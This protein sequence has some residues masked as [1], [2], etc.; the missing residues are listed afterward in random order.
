MEITSEQLK[1]LNKL[2]GIKAKLLKTYFGYFNP[3]Y[4][5]NERKVYL[6]QAVRSSTSSINK[7][8][9]FT[10]LLDN[11]KCRHAKDIIIH[12]NERLYEIR[13]DLFPETENE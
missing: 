5:K 10:F 1:A 11:I 13:P 3:P 6:F 7:L 12:N 4:D 2:T 9:R 8:K